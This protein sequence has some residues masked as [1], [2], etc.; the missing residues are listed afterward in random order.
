[1]LSI[2]IPTYNYNTFALISE[3][4]KQCNQIKDLKFEIIVNDDASEQVFE[5]KLIQQLANCSIYFQE[6]NQGLSASRNF[7]IEKATYQWCLF[8]DDDVWPTSK[9]F[10]LNY[11]L[12]IKKKPDACL[13]FGG[14]EY[15]KTKPN[16]NELL[17][18]IYGN[19]HEALSYKERIKHKPLHV[20]CSN[21]LVSKSVLE[22]VSFSK[23]INSYGYEDLIFNLKV[24]EKE[25][26]IFQI[27]NSV[28]HE[29]L[30]NSDIFLNKTRK[31]LDN[32]SKSIYLNLLSEDATG[33]SRIYNRFNKRW[34]V[35][36]VSFLFSI[37]SRWMEKILVSK[38]TNLNIY[39]LYR[40]GYFYS[41]HK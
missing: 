3:L 27:D 32:L 12:E 39:N 23:E 8:L 25:I 17:R 28:F 20:L 16:S 38:Y 22:C 31:A 4:S 34:L 1:M 36:L 26:P 5:N 24:I 14:L 37:N 6:K 35:K 30:D 18:W 29:K 10:I 15:T 11:I 7:L 13:I 33:I 41:I 21:L 2:L 19:K 9:N 40:L